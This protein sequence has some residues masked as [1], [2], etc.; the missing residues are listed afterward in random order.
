MKRVS[1][2][3]PGVTP[4][5]DTQFRL[6]T[7]GVDIEPSQWVAGTDYSVA[8]ATD[9]PLD[10]FT[11]LNTTAWALGSA[12]VGWRKVLQVGGGGAVWWLLKNPTGLLTRLCDIIDIVILSDGNAHAVPDA[13]VCLK[14]VANPVNEL[15][16][17]IT[18]TGSDLTTAQTY[19]N[20]TTNIYEMAVPITATKPAYNQCKL[21]YGRRIKLTGA[22][23]RETKT[24]TYRTSSP[25]PATIVSMA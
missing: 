8:V 20:S 6:Q 18:C 21:T 12:V 3:I 16:C 7:I 24:F 15:L 9:G 5:A 11:D 14:S 22:T 2:Y 13:I 23:S 17:P 25:C 1:T 10:S 19:Y 4:T